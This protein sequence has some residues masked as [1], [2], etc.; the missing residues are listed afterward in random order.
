MQL[1]CVYVFQSSDAGLASAFVSGSDKCL[2]ELLFTALQTV[3]DCEIKVVDSSEELLSSQQ[4]RSPVK[5]L[6][7]PMKVCLIA[8]FIALSYLLLFMALS[9]FLLLYTFY[10]FYAV[11]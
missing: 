9:Y 6:L 4:L 11:L 2:G 3:E 10:V 1:V 8:L 5:R 7:S